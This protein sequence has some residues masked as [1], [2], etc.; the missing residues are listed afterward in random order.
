LVFRSAIHARRIP[1]L[2]KLPSNLFQ[3]PGLPDCPTVLFRVIMVF[4]FFLRPFGV[5]FCFRSVRILPFSKSNCGSAGFTQ[6][7]ISPLGARLHCDRARPFPMGFPL[8]TTSLVERSRIALI[9]FAPPFPVDDASFCSPARIP[10]P[11]FL[12][13]ESSRQ[14]RCF[15]L[16]DRFSILYLQF[17]PSLFL[18][19]RRE[20]PPFFR[21]SVPPPRTMRLSRPAPFSLWLPLP[22]AGR[23]WQFFPP[24]SPVS[25]FR[26][27][28]SLQTRHPRRRMGFSP[29]RLGSLQSLLIISLRPPAAFPH[30]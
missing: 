5:F 12:R 1:L 11:F 4:F 7:P 27:H 20:R 16:A 29:R 10:L 14:K 15:W 21:T 23:V 24:F 2:S 28:Y 17:S 30:R 26:V 13:T 8:S 6:H 25:L 3:L 9:L 18:K 19:T 22:S